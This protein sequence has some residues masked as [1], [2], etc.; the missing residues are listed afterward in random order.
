MD[1]SAVP[2]FIFTFPQI[3]FIYYQ[4]LSLVALR[5]YL[6]ELHHF[7]RS[8]AYFLYPLPQLQR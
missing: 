6:A 7:S 8:E 1:R 5:Q 4:S 2:H 3:R